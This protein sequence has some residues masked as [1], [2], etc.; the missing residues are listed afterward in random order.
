M[1]NVD[2]MACIPLYLGQ[3]PLAGSYYAVECTLCGWV[4]S[5]EV[6]TD[7][8]QCTRDVGDRLCL[9]DTEEIG[10]KRLLEIV[11][12]MGTR[13]GESQQAYHRLIDHTNETEHCLDKAAELLG[14]IVQ[15]GQAYSE[16]T[17]KGS[18]TG[19]RVAAVLGY[20]AQF[21]SE[22]HQKDEEARDEN[23]QVNQGQIGG[24]NQHCIASAHQQRA[25]S[26]ER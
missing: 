11:Q 18:A 24:G 25:K 23:W 14:E 3:E 22:P 8:C 2:M 21:Q 16:C 17:D 15:S 12:A 4:G 7:D 20:V 19:L 6:L 26:F 5:S 1:S 9:G 13:H 10:T